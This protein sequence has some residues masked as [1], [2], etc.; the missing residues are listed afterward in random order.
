LI[1][2]RPW[3]GDPTLIDLSNAIDYFGT[4]SEDSIWERAMF[5]DFNSN[6]EIDISDIT[7]IAVRIRL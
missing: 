4:S 6:G 2:G 7:Y 1:T 3:T 5:Y